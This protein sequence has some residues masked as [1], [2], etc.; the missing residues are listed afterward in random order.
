MSTRRI[1]AALVASLVAC[2]AGEGPEDADLCAACGEPAVVGALAEPELAELSGVAASARFPDVLYAH[3]DSGDAAR[4]FALSR[5]GEALAVFT[6]QGAKNVDW[7]EMGRGPCQAG[8]CLFIADTGDNARERA[9]YSVYRVP[10]PAAIGAGA[11][12]IAGDRIDF[13]YPDGPHDA[14]TLLVH[15][16]S[17]VLTIVTKVESGPA[18]IHE[19]PPSLSPGRVYVSERVGELAPPKGDD[20]FTGG[21]VHPEG[22]A[23]LLR[24][25]GKLF[26]YP[27][28]PAQSVAEALAGT[29]C[30]LPVA[31]ETMGE[32]VTWLASGAE[33]VT[34]GEGAGAAVHVASCGS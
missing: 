20:R 1:F 32:A 14:E 22:T 27:M 29:P 3:N 28:E 9:G 26:R 18:Q 13:T 17:G 5:S 11:Q 31:M 10:E 7:E 30:E 19:L 4:F 8:S 12:S 21:A 2:G 23:V 16:F 15:P 33:I 24:T 6:V 34:I 25:R